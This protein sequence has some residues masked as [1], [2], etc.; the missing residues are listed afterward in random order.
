MIEPFKSQR[1]RL[2]AKQVL[3]K[4][5]FMFW[6]SGGYIYYI[7][8]EITDIQG[9]NMMELFKPQRPRQHQ[10]SSSKEWLHTD[11][12]MHVLHIYTNINVCH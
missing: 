7:I 12:C 11:T 1:S 9:I 3:Q 4:N 5:G 2:N 8:C 6:Q 10:A